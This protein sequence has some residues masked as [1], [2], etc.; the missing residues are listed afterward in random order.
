M[1]YALFCRNA[2]RSHCL[3]RSAAYEGSRGLTTSVGLTRLQSRHPRTS[4]FRGVRCH[5]PPRL[6]REKKNTTRR[7]QVLS[8]Y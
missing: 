3:H 1:T 6:A 7:P 4:P 5:L 2:G 8:Q